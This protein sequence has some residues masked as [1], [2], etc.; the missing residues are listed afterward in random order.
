MK[1]GWIHAAGPAEVRQEA[2][3]RL[4]WIADSYLPVSAPV[5]HAAARWLELTPFIQTNI[6]A[7]TC[8][9]LDSLTRAISPESGWRVM[10]SEGGWCAVLEAPRFHSEEEWVQ[11]ILEMYSVQMQPGYFYDFERGVFL[12]ASLLVE[13]EIMQNALRRASFL[14]R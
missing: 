13:P 9:N 10:P 3:E 4:E 1:L 12:V 11:S 8:I 6:R 14:A 5:Q 2:L 7:R